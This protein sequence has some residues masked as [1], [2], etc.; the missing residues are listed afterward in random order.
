MT[1]SAVRVQVGPPD[2]DGSVKDAV[3]HL[4]ETLRLNP[5]H[6]RAIALDPASAQK[7]R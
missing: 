7:F 4:N 1:G 6:E 3:L 2:A 5:Q